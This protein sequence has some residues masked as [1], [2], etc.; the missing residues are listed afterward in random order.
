MGVAVE[1]LL[2]A[3]AWFGHAF[4]WT[5]ILNLIF[6][7]AMWRWLQKRFR[8]VVAFLVFSFPI[9]LA[10]VYFGRLHELATTA[11]GVDLF[12]S[13][14]LWLCWFTTFVYVPVITVIRSHRKLPKEVAAITG[15][16]EDVAVRLGEKPVGD[17]KKWHL[18]LLPG[19]QCFTVELRDVTLRL[20]RLPAAWDGLTI[21]HLTDL[22]FCGT[23]DRAYYR[24]VFDLAVAGGTPDLIAITGDV[25]DSYHHHRWIVPLIGRLK[26]THGI[27]AVLGNHDRFHDPVIVRKRLKRI[28]VKVLGNSWESIDVR[29]EPLVVIGQE[30][31]W[32]KPAPDLARAPADPFRL[33]LSHTPDHF[34]WARRHAIDLMLAGH[35]HGGQVR[36]P[37]LGSLFVP[38]LY[39]RKYDCGAF[40]AGPTV[41]YVSRGL[42]GREPLRYNCRPEVTRVILRPFEDHTPVP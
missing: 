8:E 22:H 28:G 19:N 26:A 36:V 42:A 15:R 41:M 21:L 23:P 6:A 39:S 20:P 25:V 14:Y 2:F 37:V 30:T 13:A 9:V 4:L 33:C 7:Q 29:G 24:E 1:L 18:S 35:V 40:A 16:V 38:S 17:G 5:V 3:A 12:A 27:Y 34:A 32:F 31:P 11:S 10:V